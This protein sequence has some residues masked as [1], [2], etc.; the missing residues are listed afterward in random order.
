MSLITSPAPEPRAAFDRISLRR[1]VLIR[2]VAVAGQALALLVVHYVLEFP[3]P[4]APAFG[5][6]ACSAALNLFFAFHHRAATRLGERQAAYFLGYDLLQ[7]GLLLYLTGGL[8][9]PFSILIL[10]PV[11]VAATILSRPPVI[12]LA[13]FAVAII[14]VLA[15]WHVPLPWRSAPPLFP[16]E[17]VLGIWTAL[18]VATAFIGAY[19][20]SVAAEARRLRDAVAATQLALAREQRVSAV[21]GLAAAAAHEL[22]SPLATIAVVAKELARELPPDSPYAEDAALLL[23]QSERCRRILA[24]LTRAPEEDGGAPYESLPISA[25]VETT[26]L[27]HDRRV[28]LIFATAQRAEEDEPLVRRSPEI[29]QGIGNIVQNAVSFAHREIRIATR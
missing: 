14:T 26:A 1:L 5:V 4:L 28:R 21:G 13:I 6:V 23:S 15:F 24:D 20:W 19:T 11:T 16:P 29:V 3:L 17:L 8:Q 27:S 12:A 25:L 7:L 2:W 9:N 18:T 10:A 22:G